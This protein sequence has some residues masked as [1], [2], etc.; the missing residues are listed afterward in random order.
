MGGP[1]ETTL[2][3]A[4]AAGDRNPERDNQMTLLIAFLLLYHIEAFPLWY[5]VVTLM[6]LFHVGF[7]DE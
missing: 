7:H 3:T 5:P 2:L 6:W 4:P 1:L